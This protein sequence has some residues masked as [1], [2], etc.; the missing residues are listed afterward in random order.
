[1]MRS[2]K[3]LIFLCSKAAKEGNKKLSYRIA[4]RLEGMGIARIGTLAELSRQHFNPAGFQTKMIFI[5]NCRA[6]CLR[7]LTNGFDDDRYIYFDVSQ[8][9]MTPKFDIDHYINTEIIPKVNDKW[10]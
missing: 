4:S 6:G 1:M 3:L 7:V 8:F 9:L 10:L 2:E 5:N